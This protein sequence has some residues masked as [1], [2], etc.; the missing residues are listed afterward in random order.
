MRAHVRNTPVVRR[1]PAAMALVLLVGSAVGAPAAQLPTAREIVDRHVDAIGGRDAILGHSSSMAAGSLEVVGQGLSG[2]M[3]IYGAAPSNTLVIV[4]F[5]AMGMVSRTGYN[6]EVGWSTDPMTGPRL[7]LSGEL[8]QF[9]DES[10]YYS[11]LHESDAIASMETLEQVEFAG[12]ATYRLK[13]V[14][15]SGREAFEYYD[16]DTGRRAGT[17]GV[18]ESLM[19]ILNVVTVLEDYRQFGNVMVPTRMT[20]EFGPGQTV[21]VTIEQV[22]FGNVDPEIFALP[23]EI[24]ALLRD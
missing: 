15:S 17:E 22:E 23:A 20:Q 3:T 7:L 10:D 16:V 6:G 21:V 8:Q 11:D 1:V 12:H 9:A 19:G 13:V 4:D 2:S 14:Y 18:Q 5:A 24:Q